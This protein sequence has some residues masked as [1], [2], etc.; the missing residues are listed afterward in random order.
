MQT[1]IFVVGSNH[2]ILEGPQPT[3]QESV[4]IAQHWGVVRIGAESAS[5]M[6][7]KWKISRKAL[8]EDLTWAI[9]I[10]SAETHSPAVIALLSELRSRGIAATRV[11]GSGCS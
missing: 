4:R 2:W 6:F 3:V 5:A 1:G 9:V 11:R 10:E 7:D 8:R